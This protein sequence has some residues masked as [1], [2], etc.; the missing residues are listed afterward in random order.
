MEESR[1]LN[2]ALAENLELRAQVRSRDAGVTELME[3][4][5][6]MEDV[7]KRYASRYGGAP[8]NEDG[9]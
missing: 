1:S 9:E 3:K 5:R 8:S 6:V 4:V 2:L 7:I